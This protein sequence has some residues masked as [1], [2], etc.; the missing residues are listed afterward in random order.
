[1]TAHCT[2]VDELLLVDVLVEEVE[3]TVD[4]DVEVVEVVRTTHLQAMHSAPGWQ[5]TKALFGEPVPRSQVSLHCSSRIPLPHSCMQ[6][7]EVVV[8]VDVDTCV[9]EELDEVLVEVVVLA[10][11]LLVVVVD[12]VVWLEV[13]DEVLVVVVVDDGGPGMPTVTPRPRCTVLTT[14]RPV[15]VALF[16]TRS[17]ASGAQRSSPRRSS[18]DS[19]IAPPRTNTLM[20]EGDTAGD[21]GGPAGANTTPVPNL[22]PLLT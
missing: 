22:I 2:L 3:A 6:V 21:D 9:E 18:C 15:S 20:S 7:L 16:F 8:V 13:V 17:A 4:D 19:S 5:A 11:W 1:L 14:K 12:V 10:G